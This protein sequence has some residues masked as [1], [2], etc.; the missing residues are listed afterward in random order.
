MN[1]CGNC[2]H[3]YFDFFDSKGNIHKCKKSTYTDWIV[4]EK[5]MNCCKVREGRADCPLFEEK[6]TLLKRII[7]LFKK[8]SR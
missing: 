5:Y 4:G 1:I 7:N 8:K 2:R 3:Y 6:P